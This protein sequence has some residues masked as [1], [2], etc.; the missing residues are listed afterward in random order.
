MSLKKR[1]VDKLLFGFMGVVVVGALK[2]K[3]RFPRGQSPKYGGKTRTIKRKT[4]SPYLVKQCTKL[5]NMTEPSSRLISI[6]KSHDW[7]NVYVLKYNFTVRIEHV[8]NDESVIYKQWNSIAQQVQNNLSN[9]DTEKLKVQLYPILQIASIS[10]ASAAITNIKIITNSQALKY[11]WMIIGQ[12]TEKTACYLL[13]DNLQNYF[14]LNMYSMT[15]LFTT[16]KSAFHLS[17]GGNWRRFYSD[18]GT[19]TVSMAGSFGGKALGAS[20]GTII[21]P[22]VGTAVGG[23][24]G[25]LFGGIGGR[26]AANVGTSYLVVG[27]ESLKENAVRSTSEAYQRGLERLREYFQKS[28]GDII[29]TAVQTAID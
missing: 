1:E 4:R 28:R 25:G 21:A 22:G 19:S 12:A 9:I 18:I 5:P 10:A 16:A 29:N 8:K 7:K 2:Y 27:A 13:V 26:Y 24:V 20:V 11:A 15:V 23:V 3:T 14:P 6:S 17:K